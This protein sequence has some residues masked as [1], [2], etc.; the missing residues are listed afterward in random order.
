MLAF[1]VRYGTTRTVFLIGRHAIKVPALVEW[2]LFLKGLL[3]NMQ[4]VRLHSIDP[5]NLC[6]AKTVL[7]GGF[8]IVMPRCSPVTRVEFEEYDV[9]KQKIAVPVEA[10]MDSFGWLESRIVAVDYGN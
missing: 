4:E 6:P 8:A 1:E 3:A 9:L 5:V 7:P 2:R 10:K